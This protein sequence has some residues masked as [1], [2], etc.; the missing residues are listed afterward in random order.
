M[1]KSSTNHKGTP[2][3]ILWIR[4]GRFVFGKHTLWRP[5]DECDAERACF[6]NYCKL[7][8]IFL[9]SSTFCKVSW[10]I[11][12]SKLWTSSCFVRLSISCNSVCWHFFISWQTDSRFV[13]YWKRKAAVILLHQ[14]VCWKYVHWNKFLH[15]FTC[16]VT[17]C[18]LYER[19]RSVDLGVL[20]NSGLL[21]II[22]SD[23]LFWIVRI[24]FTMLRS[25]WVY[26]AWAC[27]GPPF[28]H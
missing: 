3:T 7:W 11:R 15:S 23:W 5:H 18:M 22:T 14:Q 9:L 20:C 12:T 19:G 25:A 17:H 13:F 6:I 26:R 24:S 4:K 28:S 21:A 16:T 27:L 10:Q 8:L 1:P 2:V